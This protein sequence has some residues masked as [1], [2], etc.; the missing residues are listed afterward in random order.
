MQRVSF[1]TNDGVEIV[2]SFLEAPAQKACA[3]LL[4]MMPVTKESWYE[5]MQKLAERGISSL[6]ID[7]R[8]HG[9]SRQQGAKTLDYKK[10]SDEDHQK[11]IHDVEVAVSWLKAQGIGEDRVI[12]IGASIGANLALQYAAEH[13]SIKTVALLSPGLDYRG[14]KTES[15]AK[16]MK[17]EQ[18]VFLAASDDDE[19]SFRT[20]ET[21]SLSLKNSSTV[22]RLHATGH[23]TDMFKNRPEFLQTIVGWIIKI[24]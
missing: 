1:P 12:I 18:S 2:G 8:G 19:Y 9:E 20:I 15:A 10:F 3:L 13:L 7:L 16:Q 24:N 4:H 22:E 6:A 17:P 5:L 14:I 21:L 23:G 11:T